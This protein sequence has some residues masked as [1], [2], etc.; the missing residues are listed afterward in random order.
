MDIELAVALFVLWLSSTAALIAFVSMWYFNKGESFHPH[1][2]D[3]DRRHSLFV[4]VHSDTVCK[5]DC[6]VKSISEFVAPRGSSSNKQFTV[7]CV[8]ISISGFLGTFRWYKVRE[9]EPFV[10]I[11]GLADT[12]L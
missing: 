2:V 1:S 10:V 11:L 4:V 7:L 9:G 12:F 8:M 5:L 3:V 6:C